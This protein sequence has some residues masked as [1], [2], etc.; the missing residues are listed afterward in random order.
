[1]QFKIVNQKEFAAGVLFVV[2]GIGW[3]VLSLQLKLGQATRMGPG[4]FPLCMSIALAGI[5]LLSMVRST[6]ALELVTLEHFPLISLLFL[7]VG[8]VGFGLLIRTAGLIPA[9]LW[10]VA[11]S[12]HRLW[13]S[14]P[15]EAAILCIAFTAA[16]SLIFV[17]GLGLPL[18][19]YSLSF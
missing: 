6:R 7:I 1:M 2:I 14:R 19:L 12:C 5:G 11:F 9:S 17:Y 18:K 4:Y 16:A 15:I 13:K 10:V 8:M 3:S